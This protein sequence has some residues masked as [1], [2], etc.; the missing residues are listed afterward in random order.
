MLGVA[1]VLRKG[2]ASDIQ[3]KG[4]IKGPPL[5]TLLDCDFFL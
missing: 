5:F 2:E 1:C 3:G 4:K